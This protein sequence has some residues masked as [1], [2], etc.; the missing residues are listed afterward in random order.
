MFGTYGGSRKYHSLD[1]AIGRN[2]SIKSDQLATEEWEE[3]KLNLLD[4]NW[5]DFMHCDPARFSARYYLTSTGWSLLHS[6]TASI[7]CGGYGFTVLE[8]SEPDS[9]AQP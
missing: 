4:D 5:C 6:P 3:V 8:P 1:A 7:H 9:S 2:T